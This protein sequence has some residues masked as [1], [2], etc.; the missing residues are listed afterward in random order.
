MYHNP[1]L[2]KPCVE[3]IHRKLLDIRKVGARRWTLSIRHVDL[4]FSNAFE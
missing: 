2:M 4:K 3:Q 1:I